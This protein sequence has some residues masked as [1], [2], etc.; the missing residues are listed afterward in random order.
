MINLAGTWQMK[1]TKDNNWQAAIVP[2]TVYTDLLRNGNM[3]DPFWR[4]NEYKIQE[5]SDYDYEY[6][7]AFA[8]TDEDLAS[9]QL[10]LVCEGLDT[11]TELFIN[12]TLIAKTDNM[13]RT[14]RFDI[15]PYLQSGENIIRIILRS[16]SRFI[17]KADE[18]KPVWG[19]SRTVPG[20]QHIR[21]AHCMFGWDW[22]P[23]LPDLG[24]FRDIYIEKIA[25]GRVKDF[26]VVQDHE[27]GNV[28][29]DIDVEI[30]FLQNT[31]I[32]PT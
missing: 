25:E 22:G 1:C 28:R 24:I 4:E 32:N 14:Y 18:K 7:R 15:K 20:Y 23:K 5:L 2:G 3:D 29:L 17:A 8:V 30:D 9:Q 16:P 12:K 26:Y 13:H 6:Q 31:F 19:V 11:L 10:V 21:K 27:A